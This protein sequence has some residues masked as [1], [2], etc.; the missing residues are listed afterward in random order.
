ML[1]GDGWCCNR[2]LDYLVVVHI[3]CSYTLD[4]VKYL[5]RIRMI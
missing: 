4:N 5:V 1:W 2:E 3:I